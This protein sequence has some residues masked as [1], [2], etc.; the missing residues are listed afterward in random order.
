MSR[1]MITQKDQD[2]IKV[3]STALDVDQNKHVVINGD[4]ETYHDVEVENNLVVDND[5][6]VYG[7]L[8]VNG[9]VKYHQAVIPEYPATEGTYVLKLTVDASGHA[10]FA[11]IAG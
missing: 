2:Y 1:R 6:D 10:T 7:E 3:L 4:I 8:H 11:W 5:A 9:G